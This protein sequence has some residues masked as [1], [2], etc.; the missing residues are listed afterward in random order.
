MGITPH[1]PGAG[2]AGDTADAFFCPAL[3]VIVEQLRMSPNLAGAR[4]RSP[5]HAALGE[6]PRR[7]AD[8]CWRGGRAG[9]TFLAFGNG[10]PDAAA[11]LAAFISGSGQVGVAA[12]LGAGVFVTTVVVGAVGLVSPPDARLDRR[13]F[14]RDVG[15]YILA[16]LYLLFVFLDDHLTLA[17]ALGFNVLYAIFAVVVVVG[18]RIY[19]SRK[20]ARLAAAAAGGDSLEAPLITADVEKSG[21]TGGGDGKRG[22]AA[23]GASAPCPENNGSTKE[24]AEESEGADGADGAEP[25]EHIEGAAHTARSISDVE[26]G[27]EERAQLHRGRTKRLVRQRS[28]S[29]SLISP[30][31]CV[32][33]LCTPARGSAV[34]AHPFL[35]PAPSGPQTIFCGGRPGRRERG[36]AHGAD[37][38][39]LPVPA[40]GHLFRAPHTAPAPPPCSPGAGRGGG[41]RRECGADPGCAGAARCVGQGGA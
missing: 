25:S 12:I 16:V 22:F 23:A 1:A 41:A 27:T 18:R 8:P 3:D 5:T 40:R 31:P 6:A 4:C 11:S 28:G 29:D 37:G 17:E 30:S 9:V 2:G 32:A 19:Q 20:Q 14:F 26:G 24:D 7:L 36:P 21:A 33:D 13:P 10:A 38:A 15:F 35:T 34:P 39:P